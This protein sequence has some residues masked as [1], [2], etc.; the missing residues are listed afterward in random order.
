MNGDSKEDGEEEG[1][2]GLIIDCRAH[3]NA[4]TKIMPY[5]FIN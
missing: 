3:G 1:A 5:K 2:V 4:I